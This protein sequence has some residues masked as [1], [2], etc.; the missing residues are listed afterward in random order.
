MIEFDSTGLFPPQVPHT[1]KLVD[2]LFYNGVAL[3][4]SSTG[5]GKMYCGAAIAR[6]FDGPI[7]VVAPKLVL[8]IWE[9]I[10]ARFGKKAFLLINYEKLM[11][12]NTPWLKY[13]LPA[14]KKLKDLAGCVIDIGTKAKKHRKF[15]PDETQARYFNATIHFP[16][17]CLVICD[18]NHKMKGIN[19]LNC[20]FGLALRRQGYRVLLASATAAIDPTDMRSLAYL[21]HLTENGEMKTFK[22][23]VVDAGGEF[24]GHYG[25]MI[26]DGNNP[27]S[28]AKLKGIHDYLFNELNIA[29]RLTPS[30]MGTFF[31]ENDMLAESYDMGA[32]SERIARAYEEMEYDI[33]RLDK[34]TENYSGHIF[35]VI[36][37]ARRKIEI[38]KLPSMYDFVTDFID[39]GKN[40]IVF[41]NFTD[42]I[43]ALGAK[44]ERFGKFKDKNLIGYLYGNRTINQRSQDIDDF[45]A[46]KKRVMLVNLS[47]AESIGLHDITGK[48]PRATLIN[49]T[50]SPIRT[51]QSI[52][53][54]Y[55]SE[56]KS[57][58]IQRFVY[59]DGTIESRMAER[60]S[61]R[62]NSLELLTAGDLTG[63]I[64]FLRCAEGKEI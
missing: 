34:A 14:K 4:L 22:K 44:L 28:Q 31:P 57:K 49:P 25:S 29:S 11:R 64:N 20:G 9:K 32:N 50:F 5:C 40:V 56:G 35:A 10:L 37:K 46:D 8:R 63:S 48:F 61:C 16:A 43:E 27:K 12:G 3:D 7:V 33:A 42:S 58:V 39:E 17:G 55:R 41:L 26:F 23:F 60:L 6:N 19:S 30:M 24:T 38:L 53:R 59:A 18:E 54:A 52:G 13:K 1:K 47:V 15:H 21:T 62:L 2:S 45:Q 36:M 51:L